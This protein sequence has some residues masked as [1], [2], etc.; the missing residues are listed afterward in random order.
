M[1]ANSRTQKDRTSVVFIGPQKGNGGGS[2]CSR[3]NAVMKR[4]PK[5]CVVKSQTLPGNSRPIISDSDKVPPTVSVW[6]ELRLLN[7]RSAF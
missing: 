6:A 7:M 3:G 1:V 4:P 5:L 2:S